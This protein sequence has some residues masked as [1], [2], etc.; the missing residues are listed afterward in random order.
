MR[1]WLFVCLLAL[2]PGGLSQTGD[3]QNLMAQ[4]AACERAGR[5][6]EA[7]AEYRSVLRLVEQSSPA[8]ARLP[9]ILIALASASSNLGD[10]REAE[11]LYRRAM[12]L[13]ETSAGKE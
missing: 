11:R 7:V 2:V 10:F 6:A 9:G 3:W 1:R 5:Y 13:V 8:D 12:S 4:A